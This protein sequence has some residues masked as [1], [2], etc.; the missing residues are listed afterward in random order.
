MYRIF[1]LKC[2]KMSNPKG[3]DTLIPQFSW[4]M[5]S[6]RQDT[7]QTAYEIEVRDEDENCLWSVCRED[8]RNFGI[9][10]DGAPLKT[11]EKYVWTVKSINNYGESFKSQRAYFEMG[12]TDKKSWRAKWIEAPQK[13]KEIKDIT[14]SASIFSGKVR[15]NENQEEYLNPPV[16]FRKRINI[17]KTV[18]RAKVYA[19]AHGVYELSIDKKAFSEVLAPGYTAYGKYLDYQSYDVAEYLTLGWHELECILADGWYSGKIGL[20][21]VGNQYG[22]TNAFLMQME[23]Q[24][25][26]GSVEKIC[27]DESFEWAEGAYNY[28]DIFV[29]ESIDYSKP[30]PDYQSGV[31]VKEY[32]YENL[33]G[34]CC[35]PVRVLR[36]KKPVKLIR[37][38]KGEIVL[39]AGENIAG[40]T[41]F[42]LKTKKGMVI[43]LEHS[44][45]LDKDGNFMQNIMGQNKNQKDIIKCSGKKTSYCPK[46]TFHGFRYVKVTGF[47][48]EEQKSINKDDFTI[49][50]IGTDLEKTGEFV[51]SNEKINKLQENIYRSQ[52]GNMVSVPTDCPQRERAGWT[53]DMQVY[54]Q[55]AVF[56]MNVYAFL[57]K[58]LE[59]M[60][61]E[62]LD[63][64]QIPNVV[65]T[66]D[67]NK[68]I[69]GENR[70]HICSAG[71]GDAC[72]IVPYRMYMAYGDKKILQ[73]NY[74][75]MKRWLKY[76]ENQASKYTPKD[77]LTYSIE[78]KERQKYLWNTEFHFGDW[79]IPSIVAKTGNPMQTAILTKEQAATAM[80]A[81][82]TGMMIEI[83]TILGYYEEA[84][85][86]TVLNKKICEAFSNEYI[87]EDGSIEP[88]VQGIYVLALYMGM[89]AE[90]K[91]EKCVKKLVELIHANNDCLD[92]GFLSVP[93][94]L[95]TLCKYGESELAYTLL[96][97]EKCPSWLYEVN[98][99]ATTVWENWAA[100]L[101]NGT[102]TN[103]SY[104]HFA[105]GCVGD[106][107]YRKIGGIIMEEAGYKKILI[108]PDFSCGL[109]KVYTSLLT[110]YGKLSADWE[111]KDGRYLLKIKLPPN[112]SGRVKLADKVFE[113]GNGEFEFSV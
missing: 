2:N 52:Q 48:E 112:T 30:E 108:E 45:I 59:N 6:D 65:P 66:I 98:M 49:V 92:T 64:G 51:T 3:I 85:R 20:M 38:P 77:V 105:F 9:E 83:N 56:N 47:D 17:S 29:G 100:I 21:G 54:A 103:S 39:D 27:S 8:G 82:T 18:K 68:Y 25:E 57:D 24:Y 62:Q 110:P 61:L 67:S 88:N 113:I 87:K 13:R 104:N 91:R 31:L 42:S 4:R 1:D 75:M 106:F 93:F 89:A 84:K 81:Y 78:E 43:G 50:I 7:F 16:Y 35:E 60:R 22:S 15:S 90:D 99:G 97:Q 53:G 36:E 55:T 70:K 80:Y 40:Y 79:L 23:I 101:P 14:D 37:T 44:E 94:L 74:E 58:W 41:K 33:H 86:Y 96:Y 11:G 109:D 5:E 34:T 10:Y 46:F 107:M 19:T 76:V 111:K 102:R 95:D 12:I 71:W 28:A 26:D 73:N 63:D 72:I 69:D 32:G